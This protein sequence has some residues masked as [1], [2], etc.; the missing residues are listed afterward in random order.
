MLP[1]LKRLKDAP[2]YKAYTAVSNALKPGTDLPPLRVALLRNFT[3]E[4]LVPVIEG[5]LALAGFHAQFFIGD[6]DAIARDALDAESAL[7]RFQ[8]E[9]ILVTE[10]LETLSPGLAAQFTTLGDP[11][12][13]VRRVLAARAEVLDALRRHTKAPVLINNF[14]LPRYAALGILDAQSEAY[15]THSILKLNLGLLEEARRWPDVYVVDWMTLAARLGSARAFDDRYW[16]IGRAPL[17][18]E[19]L[20][21]FGRELARFICALRGKAR[22]C[23]VL[24]CD[25]TLWGGIVGEAGLRG[26]QVSPA[27]QAFQR[28]ILNL[29]GRG[30]ILALCSK[31]NEADALEVLREHPDMLLK[32]EHFAAREINWNDKAENLRSLAVTLNIGLDA[33][34][35]VDDSAFECDLVRELLPEVAVLH[36]EGDPSGFAARLAE[37]AYFDTLSFSK[38]DRERTRLY[39]DEAERRQLQQAAGSLEEYLARLELVAEIGEADERSVPRIAQLTQKTN[40]FNLTTRR[41]SEGE[42]QA[43]AREGGVYWLKL[44]DRVAELGL[45]GVAIVKIRG[46]AAEIDTLLMSC[47]ALGRGAEQCLLA[48]AVDAARARGC[49]RITARYLRTAKNGQAAD[50]YRRQGLQPVRET[51]DESEWAL[52]LAEA[53]VCAPPWIKVEKHGSQ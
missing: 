48:Q 32:E 49:R 29:H 22:K 30:V 2:D 21:P 23:L 10:W 33:L 51:A 25:G 40:Q 50:F 44:R 26:I 42:I 31:N 36:L 16:Q 24:D 43:L 6:Y 17:G 52:D 39:R 53:G 19:A 13:E 18:R 1:E 47:R 12:A 4:T 37:G 46:E 8:P 3:S 9:F 27:Y 34:V 15:Q 35:F 41:Y 7:Y 20:V 28:E 45:V 14:P 11:A 38:E 5:E